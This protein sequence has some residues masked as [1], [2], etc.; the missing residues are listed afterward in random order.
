MWMNP[1]TLII[2]KGMAVPRIGSNAQHSGI[3]LFIKS[4]FVLQTKASKQFEKVSL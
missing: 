3:L 4:G 2:N 1:V